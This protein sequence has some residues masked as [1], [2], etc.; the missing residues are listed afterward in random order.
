MQKCSH[1]HKCVH[2]TVSHSLSEL[3]TLA[4]NVYST[5]VGG[6][7]SGSLAVRYIVAFLSTLQKY[8]HTT[9]LPTTT[10]RHGITTP[11]TEV[12]WCTRGQSVGLLNRLASYRF[13]STP[14]T[15]STF[16]CPA[17]LPL[18]EDKPP[19]NTFLSVSRWRPWKSGSSVEASY[20]FM[21]I[22]VLTRTPP[23]SNEFLDP[24][25]V[26]L[27][28]RVY[29]PRPFSPGVPC[30]AHTSLTSIGTACCEL[31]RA[32]SNAVQSYVE[33]R[34]CMSSRPALQFYGF[35]TWHLP[36]AFAGTGF[37]LLPQ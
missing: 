34:K 8:C 20:S 24:V 29:Q 3:Y 7:F 13:V 17:P 1:S 28:L 15:C 31:D 37:H 4:L 9:D 16:S 36:C 18:P 6:A 14:L 5:K 23:K 2:C 26:L 27:I 32:A 11:W 19:P 21:L 22:I 33:L 12:V 35:A 25:Y 30:P 10:R